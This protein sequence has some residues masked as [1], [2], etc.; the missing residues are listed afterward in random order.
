MSLRLE[1]RGEITGCVG[2]L[3]AAGPA[4]LLAPRRHSLGAM[5]E[6][7]SGRTGTA[8]YFAPPT[9]SPTSFIALDADTATHDLDAGPYSG[10][11]QCTRSHPNVTSDTVVL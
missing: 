6:R 10:P 5:Q 3:L 2:V 1:C 11:S 9:L 4:E 7:S 8:Y